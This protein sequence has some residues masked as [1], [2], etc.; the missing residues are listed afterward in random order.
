[1]TLAVNIAQIGSNNTTFRNR[2]INGAMGIWQRG[3]SFTSGGAATYADRWH[4]AM[5]K[6]SSSGTISRST[7]SQLD[8]HILL[9]H[10][11]LLTLLVQ[12]ITQRNIEGFNIAE[13]LELHPHQQYFSFWVRSSLTG[14]F[15]TA[16]IRGTLSIYIHNQCSKYF[17]TKNTTIAGDTTGC[18]N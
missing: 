13:I 3:T 11:H 9:V 6:S 1:M 10:L 17:G 2:I 16:T 4:V 12:V 18:R 15:G 7:A 8:L 5:V 14:A